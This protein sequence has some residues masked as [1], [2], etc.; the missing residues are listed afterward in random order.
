VQVTA[1]RNKKWSKRCK[2]YSK[3]YFLETVFLSP[4]ITAD[5]SKSADR[6]SDITHKIYHSQLSQ[7]PHCR[8]SNCTYT[9]IIT[10]NSQQ[11]TPVHTI[12]TIM[13]ITI[14]INSKTHN[15]RHARKS[16]Q[17]FVLPLGPLPDDGNFLTPGCS[18]VTTS[19]DVRLSLP[20]LASTVDSLST[21]RLPQ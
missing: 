4:S 17:Q 3:R 8:A 15:R 21:S 12:N 2:L 19:T 7:R 10:A 14:Q 9:I 11:I 18:L 16:R 5:V 6:Y 20:N 1:K 13:K